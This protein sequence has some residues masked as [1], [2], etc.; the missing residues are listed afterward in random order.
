MKFI[1]LPSLFL[2][3][4]FLM[5]E[6]TFAQNGQDSG[7]SESD[8]EKVVR[9]IRFSG[10][11][12]VSNYSLETLVRTRTNREFLGIKRFT[13]WYYTWQLFGVG[14]EP[15]Y[16]DR[17][18]VANDLERIRIFYENLGYLDVEVDSSIV[19]YRTNR[20]EVSF[21]IKEGP[22]STINSVAYTGLPNFDQEPGKKER[23]Y[24][25]SVFS[26]TML[27]DSTFAYS[28]A[29]RVQQLREEQTRIINF[30][31]DNGYASV[32][33][34]SVKALVKRFENN[35]NSIDIL[36]TINPGETFTFG[37]IFISL[38][39]PG[40]DEIFQDSLT[41]TLDDISSTKRTIELKKNRQAQ[42]D[43][44][45]LTD[46]LK[47]NPGDLYNQSL[48]LRTIRSYQSLGN[49]TVRRFGLNEETSQPDFTSEYIPAYFD[50]QT[51]PRHSINS[52]FFGM[53]RYG[54]G[55]GAGINYNNNNLFGRAENFTL[56]L[57]TNLEFV[58]SGTL[59]EIAPR[60]SSG[61]RTSTGS[62]IFQSYEVRGEYSVPRL[63]F[64]FRTYQ[65][66]SWVDNSRT[67]YSLTYSQSDQLFFD[68]NTDIR[69]NLRYEVQ[70]SDRVTSLLDLFE[71][72]IVDTSPSSQ[73]RQNL[74]NEFGENSFEFL[75]ISQDFD[76]Q[77]SSI[78]RYSV[79]NQNTN[80]I[81]R[82][83]GFFSEVSLA[84]GGNIPYLLDR[85]V[86]TPGDL[87]E[88]LPSPFGISSNSLSYSRFIKLS[89]D[90][91]RYIPLTQNTIFSF[92]AFGGMAQPIGQSS[93]IPL[94][95]RF[96]AG[97]SNDIRGW[98]PFRLG[99]GNISPDEVTIPGGEIKL[100]L[101]KE[102]RQVIMRDVLT[103]QWELAWHTDAGN[104]WYGPKN[105]FRDADNQELLRDGKFFLDSFYKQIAVGSGLG[106]RLD[107]EFIV[108]RFDLTFRVHDL[109]Q[110]WFQNK[111]AY[112]TF[113]IGHSF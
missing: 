10:N 105:T 85:F 73:F 106:L 27:N 81:K 36:F 22:V 57:N 95:R 33:R 76:P 66:R 102:F 39:G 75:R 55:T 19:E 104:V 42:T 13:P 62:A 30:L 52:E 41:I 53:R 6:V 72:D 108:A 107:W 34:D 18:T 49:L 111:N 24:N 1:Y 20:V 65:N 54:F 82:N 99:P 47:F 7:I 25:S 64:P 80:L 15:R 45:L 8:S 67:T 91:R 31:K 21:L 96:F 23:F 14:E 93:T 83:F 16:L 78:I 43:F 94:N 97:G 74:I 12:N 35:P 28:G 3:I 90:Y 9:K 61:R 38:R 4:F 84:L 60:D 56:S 32:Q 26:S 37:D 51:L 77:F 87:E 17:E 98:N 112:F 86:V 100:A 71:L 59:S 70:H 48:Y 92:R 79:R 58:T 113:G 44:S 63:N 110:G 68:I 88:T 11:E 89:A 40:G 103:A 46:Q 29:Y 50:L 5:A 109:E 101:F 69:F 2:T